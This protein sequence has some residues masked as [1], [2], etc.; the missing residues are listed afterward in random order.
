MFPHVDISRSAADFGIPKWWDFGIPKWDFFLPADATAFV[1][2]KLAVGLGPF[3][4]SFR[5]A[6][7]P[8]IRR[9]RTL[10]ITD[11]G[12]RESVGMRDTAARPAAANF[13]QPLI[14]ELIDRIGHIF[15]GHAVRHELRMGHDQLAVFQGGV[16]RVLDDDAEEGAAGIRTQ[17]GEGRGFQQLNRQSLPAKATVVAPAFFRS[18]RSSM[19]AHHRPR[20][21]RIGSALVTRV[22]FRH[23][24]LAPVA[25]RSFGNLPV[26]R[27]RQFCS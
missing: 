3:P 21:A 17:C 6:P 23:Q 7:F 13:Y 27:D 1:G 20:L 14:F 8:L 2:G 4:A 9:W 11:K 24:P 5:R 10:V 19:L 12:Q 18:G 25:S 22:E 16:G 26:L 15:A